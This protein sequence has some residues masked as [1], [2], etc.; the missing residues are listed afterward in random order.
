MKTF[1]TIFLELQKKINGLLFY[2]YC[3]SI[4]LCVHVNV[5]DASAGVTNSVPVTTM[6]SQH[7]IMYGFICS[8]KS[9]SAALPG[10]STIYTRE[11]AA[12]SQLIQVEG[13]VV[14]VGLI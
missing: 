4:R 1:L 11:G 8:S 7:R 5:S 6:Q 2:F 13:R 10:S 14:W 12:S 9:G 3:K